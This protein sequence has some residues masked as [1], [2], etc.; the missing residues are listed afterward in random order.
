LSELDEALRR[1][2]V[3]QAMLTKVAERQCCG[4]SGS[5]KQTCALRKDD[6]ST[7]AG[8]HHARGTVYVEARVQVAGNERLPGVDPDPHLDRLRL[9]RAVREGALRIACGQHGRTGIGEREVERVALHL[10]LDTAVFGERLPQQPAVILE[11]PNVG[12]LAEILQQPRGALDVSEEQRDR[13]A[14]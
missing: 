9:R 10:H 2:E 7:M 11:R 5:R 12:P 14:R 4:K 8:A 1:R 3:L 13:A 6:L